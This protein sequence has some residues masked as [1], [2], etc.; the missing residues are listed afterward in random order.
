MST[1]FVSDFA[2]RRLQA[3]PK[4]TVW[5]EFTPLCIKYKAVNLGQGFPNFEVPSE[6]MKHANAAINDPDPLSQQ[7]SRML[8]HPKL[9][10]QIAKRHSKALGRQIDGMNEVC[11]CNGTTQALNLCSMAFV[12][13]DEQVLV[14]EPFFDLYDNDIMIA[15]GQSKFVP[16]HPAGTTANEWTLDFE[17]LD[18]TIASNPKKIKALIQYHNITLKIIHIKK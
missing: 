15:H 3:I 11:V 4:M 8:G 9:V 18:K 13:P 16:L 5:S 2:A 1:R 17:A 14:I 12:N 10:D 7:Y 6:I